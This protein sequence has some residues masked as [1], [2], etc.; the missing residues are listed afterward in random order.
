MKAS[1]YRFPW[2]DESFDFVVLMSVFTHMLPDEMVN[3]L[4][5]IR[6][7]LRTDGKCLATF[8]ILRGK[9]KR[10]GSQTTTPSFRFDLGGCHTVDRKNPESVVAYEEDVVR[11]LYGQSKLRILEPIRYGSWTGRENLPSQQDIVLSVKPR[12]IP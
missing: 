10:L 7:V 2:N 6:R 9:S 4:S 12:R 5:E 3:Y 1:Q 11:R 8:C